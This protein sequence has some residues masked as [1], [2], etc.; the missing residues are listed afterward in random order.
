[1]PKSVLVVDDEPKI[2]EVVGDYLRRAGFSVMT[3]RCRCDQ[4][5]V[6]HDPPQPLTSLSHNTLRESGCDQPRR[7]P[8]PEAV[9][10]SGLPQ[11]GGGMRPA[12][13]S[14]GQGEADRGAAGGGI[15]AGVD[16]ASVGTD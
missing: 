15:V 2:V 13:T 7:L 5:V 1:M 8:P 11:S 14:G 4:R 3:S 10:G 6:F 16:R 9:A 12:G